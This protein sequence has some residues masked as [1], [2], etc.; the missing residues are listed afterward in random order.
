[1]TPDEQYHQDT[2]EHQQFLDDYE[3]EE[4][5]MDMSKFSGSESKH[6]KASEM[7]GANLKVVISDIEIIDFPATDTQAANS[8]A[9]LHF[10]GKEKILVLNATN[11]KI[12]CAAYGSDSEDW[13]G[14][15][16]GLS[17]AEYDNFAPGWV[18]RALDIKEPE[19]DTSIPF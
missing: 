6:L 12:L 13:K 14:H 3:R 11:N 19:F 5:Q 7:L 2:T 8:K 17:T 18:V 9:A 4:E 1:M 10:Q 16:I 15:E